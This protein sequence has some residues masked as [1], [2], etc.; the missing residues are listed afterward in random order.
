MKSVCFSNSFELFEFI[1]DKKNDVEIVACIISNL[2]GS[3]YK[4]FFYVSEITLNKLE[5]GFPFDSSSIKLCSDTELSDFYLKI[6]CQ[7]CYIEE[8]GGRNVL[9]VLGDIKR[10]NGFDYY[11]CPR[12]ILKKACDFIKKKGVADNVFIGNELEFFIF[13]KVNYSL[14]EYNSYLKIY[15]RESFCCKNDLSEVYKQN[16]INKYEGCEESSS[17]NNYLND[18]SKKVK[19]KCGYFITDPYDTS[20]I[21]KH[22]ICRDLNNLNINVQR[23]HH[24]VSTSQHE[25]SLKYFDALKNADNIFIAKHVIKKIVNTFNR[26]ATFMPKPIVSDNGT[27][28]HYNISLWK[29]NKNI[30]FIDD[31]STFFLSK[32]AFYFMNGIIKHSKALQA[33]C[34]STMNSYKRLVPGFETCQNLFYS[35]GSRSAVI[36]LSLIN[37]DNPS[38]KRIEFRLP[39]NSNSP[40]LITAAIILAGYDGIKSKDQPLVPLENRDDQFFISSIFYNYVENS[41]KFKTLTHALSDYDSMHNLKDSPNFHNFFKCKEPEM[42]SF[43]LAESLEALE[44]DHDFLTADNIFTEEMIQEYIKFKREEIFSYNKNVTALDYHLYFD[45]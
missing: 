15:D 23:Y 4:C 43:S 1:N 11:K 36:R 35:F 33:F 17:F 45:C 28:L 9:N 38:E 30:F 34:N 3:F 6:D 44:K 8:C 40:H 41:E 24:E 7:T 32:E 27:G 26:T 21:I 25:L 18:D 2:L 5:K 13:D 22:K 39:D 14:D 37:Y 16:N 19:K 10:Y 20:N 31:P 29:D 42:I 12:T